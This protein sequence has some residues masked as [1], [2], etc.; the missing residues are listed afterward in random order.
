MNNTTCYYAYSK[1]AKVST[2]VYFYLFLACGIFASVGNTVALVVFMNL[3]MSSKLTLKKSNKMLTSL[4]LSDWLVGVVLYP[5]L[6]FQMANEN[7]L[8]NCAYKY[9]RDFIVYIL[10]TISGWHLVA[11]AYE[12]FI[13]LTRPLDHEKYFPGKTVNLVLVIIWTSPALLLTF[14]LIGKIEKWKSTYTAFRS[15]V[16][17]L[18]SLALTLFVLFYVLIT[19]N[20]RIQQ[21][22]ILIKSSSTKERGKRQLKLAKKVSILLLCSLF[23]FI[24]AFIGIIVGVTTRNPDVLYARSFHEYTLFTLFMASLNSCLNPIIYT[25]KYDE[26]RSCLKK[27]IRYLRHIR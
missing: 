4:A 27:I 9:T 14:D 2:Q 20:V 8:E 5:F 10:L 16:S 13:T 23:C 24:P 3:N 22:E 25:L 15:I 26:F 1:V 17:F 12:R 21:R 6:C 11:I 18:L 7:T 19:Y